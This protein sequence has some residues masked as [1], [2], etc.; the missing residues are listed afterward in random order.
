M[1]SRND[2]QCETCGG[3]GYVKGKCHV[4]CEDCQKGRDMYWNE[5]YWEKM[6]TF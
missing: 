5:L 2:G 4:H 6:E 3:T 1:E